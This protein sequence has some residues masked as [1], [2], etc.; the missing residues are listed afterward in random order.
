MLVMTGQDRVMAHLKA[1]ELLTHKVRHPFPPKSGQ[2]FK[3]L[4][5]IVWNRGIPI[6]SIVF[7]WAITKAVTN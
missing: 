4:P 5:Q 6:P 3:L 7:I 1:R 2:H